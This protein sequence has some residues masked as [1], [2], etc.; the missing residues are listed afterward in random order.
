MLAL[1]PH[2]VVFV[3]FICDADEGIAQL[4]ELIRMGYL[5]C[6]ACGSKALSAASTCPRCAAPFSMHDGR[7]E[8]V[9]LRKCSGCGIMHRRDRSCHWCG[10][11]K[12]AAWRSPA[13]L[14]SAAGIAAVALVAVGSWSLR[15]P[16]RDVLQRAFV[17]AS[18]PVGRVADVS[19]EPTYSTAP[20]ERT[21]SALPVTA[22]TMMLASAD[23]AAGVSVVNDSIQWVPA[24]A[25]T[26]VNV[27]SDASRG[28]DVVGVIKPSEKA[29]LGIG[30]SGWRQVR[31]PDMS[32][33]VDPRLF[34]SDSLRT[35]G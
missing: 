2:E 17:E 33:W 29:M 28:G 27:H 15:E 16:A 8:R 18:T 14:K 4:T 22:D 10:D 20:T 6:E 13:V 12:P 5:R 34:E 25:R 24:V 1:E 30:R 26:W 21:L 31:L 35:R 3:H 11:I 9:P 7:G 23:G 32:G 19:S